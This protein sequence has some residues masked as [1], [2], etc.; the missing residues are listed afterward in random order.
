M[1]EDILWVVVA[2]V[3]FLLLRS[4][5]GIIAKGFGDLFSNQTPGGGA[6]APPPSA[7]LPTQETLRKDPVCGTFLPESS[8]VRK[9]VDGVT[10]YFCSA[11]CR[12][13]FTPPPH[14]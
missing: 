4:I 3:V 2:G 11:E 1:I 12:D 9:T 5:L 13:K 8:A 10:Y 14:S 6:S 7:H